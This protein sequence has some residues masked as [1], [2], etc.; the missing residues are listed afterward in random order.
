MSG[1]VVLAP[2]FIIKSLQ[3]DGRFNDRIR[4]GSQG[5]SLQKNDQ[6]FE[7]ATGPSAFRVD[8]RFN[9]QRCQH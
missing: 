2:Q 4:R 6:R 1:N 5:G 8:Q 9:C 3:N 7:D